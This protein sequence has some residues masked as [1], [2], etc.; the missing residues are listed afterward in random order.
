MTTKEDMAQN[1]K[2]G[3]FSG[4]FCEFT[5]QQDVKGEVRSYPDRRRNPYIPQTERQTKQPNKTALSSQKTQANFVFINLEF[6]QNK[7]VKLLPSDVQIQGSACE[8]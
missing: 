6:Q 7:S 8:N 4:D 5:C 3:A 2:A 1:S